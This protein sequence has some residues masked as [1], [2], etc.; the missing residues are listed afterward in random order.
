MGRKFNGN[1]VWDG[2]VHRALPDGH[3]GS[4]PEYLDPD[5]TSALPAL[6]FIVADE[7]P[8]IVE[9]PEQVLSLDPR[10][11]G[12]KVGFALDGQAL[13]DAEGLSA[14]GPENHD[15]GIPLR[16][17]VQSDDYDGEALYVHPA[18]TMGIAGGHYE[19][20]E[21]GESPG[22]V[23]PDAKPKTRADRLKEGS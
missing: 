3:D 6:R 17:L 21:A 1:V 14:T 23:F 8:E 16:D 18:R 15:Q 22:V 13:K 10:Q 5:A 11:T 19:Y 4:E 2:E 20:V 9:L 7:P 12:V